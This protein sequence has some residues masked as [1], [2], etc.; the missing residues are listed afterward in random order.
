VQASEMMRLADGMMYSA[1]KA[2]GSR[3][4]LTVLG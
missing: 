3:H 2:G 4:V 1:K